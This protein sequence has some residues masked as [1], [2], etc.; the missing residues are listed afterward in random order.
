MRFRYLIISI[1]LMLSLAACTTIGGGDSTGIPT[2]GISTP[3]LTLPTD[4]VGGKETPTLD[5]TEDV[6]LTLTGTVSV[7]STPTMVPT[8]MARFMIQPGTPKRTVN[9]AN[10]DMN[11]DWM[12]VGG[13]VFG[14]KGSPVD[15]IVVE[16]GGTIA[17]T[18]I[19]L[20]AI[21][22]NAPVFGPG[23]YI[24]ELGNTPVASEGTLWL[25]LL[26]EG[27]QQSEKILLTTSAECEQNLLLVNFS[28]SITVSD[29]QVRLPIIIK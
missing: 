17:G 1:L 8:P 14:D 18:E 19:S 25:Q 10:P 12:G 29:I 23:G 9:F 11:C 27:E 13:Q 24:F 28:E 22:G 20:L 7:P 6:V 15:G 4:I 21:T 2:E 5:H 26:S 3:S 16:L